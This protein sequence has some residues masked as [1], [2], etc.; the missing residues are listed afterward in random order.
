LQAVFFT[1]SWIHGDGIAVREVDH[2]AP[3]VQDQVAAAVA[4][5]PEVHLTE[6]LQRAVL[7][8][9]AEVS[10]VGP[11]ERVSLDRNDALWRPAELNVRRVL[12]GAPRSPTIVR[13]P[14]STHPDWARAPRFTTG[15]RGVFLLHSPAGNPVPTLAALPGD[16]LVV[17]DPDDFQPESRLADV[18]RLLGTSR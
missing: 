11:V 10:S 12:R 4:R 7:V 2:A 5:L 13:F 17:L 3:E 9:H 14:T 18:E 8:V 6:R 1:N 15:Q 16:A